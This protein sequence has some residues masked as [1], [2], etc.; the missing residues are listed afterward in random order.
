MW[1]PRYGFGS[2]IISRM[3]KLFALVGLL[4]VIYALTL[5]HGTLQQGA[6]SDGVLSGATAPIAGSDQAVADAAPR[7]PDNCNND[8][9]LA[10]YRNHQRHIEVCGYGTIARVLRDDLQGSRHQRFIV[11]LPTGQT[12][13]IAYNID[14]APRIDGLRPGTPLE[15]AG[16]YEWTGQG[17]VVHW[18]HRDPAGRHPAGWI[19][20]GGRTYQ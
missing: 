12:V 10:D 13:L 15:F 18:T 7:P 20:Y 6:L 2:R 11:R 5:V 1:R 19:R 8:A 14:L 9:L 16:E 3:R 4:G 17:G